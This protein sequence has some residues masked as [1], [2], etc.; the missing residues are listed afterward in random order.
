MQNNR[1]R[2]LFVTGLVVALLVIIETG[3]YFTIAE[4]IEKRTSLNIIE[5][6]G[7]SLR[8]AVHT[9]GTLTAKDVCESFKGDADNQKVR[10]ESIVLVSTALLAV[11]VLAYLLYTS[12]TLTRDLKLLITLEVAV[13]CVA[14][15]A[16]DYFFFKVIVDGTEPATAGGLLTKTGTHIAEALTLEDIEKDLSC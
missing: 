3:V 13:V 14:F 7:S 9:S 2:H 4:P 16:F 1:T 12:T 10:V 5:D 11:V 15:F 8:A 6:V